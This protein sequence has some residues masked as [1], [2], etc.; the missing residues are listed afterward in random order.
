MGA[1]FDTEKVHYNVE[2]NRML[3]LLSHDQLFVTPWTVAH[4]APLYMGILQTKMLE[5]VAMPPPGDL[6]SPGMEPRSLT[7]QA[8][9]FT[10]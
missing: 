7:L 10:V 5:W 4:Q 1:G 3:N 6:P 8:D 9:Y 2:L